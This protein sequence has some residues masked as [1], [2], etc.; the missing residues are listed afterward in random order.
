MQSIITKYYPCNTVL[1]YVRRLLK[2]VNLKIIVHTLQS[3]GKRVS[4]F[5][6]WYNNIMVSGVEVPALFLLHY[7]AVVYKGWNLCLYY[8]LQHLSNS[9]EIKDESW[10]HIVFFWLSVWIPLEW[11][12]LSLFFNSAESP[13]PQIQD[14]KS[15]SE[16]KWFKTLRQSEP[17]F[18]FHTMFLQNRT[19]QKLP[20]TPAWNRNRH[21]KRRAS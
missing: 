12:Y 20:F 11:S 2:M 10:I 18:Q 7:C 9:S 4:A 14:L 13:K 6:C 8:I 17:P 19:K 1:L 16:P 5:V 15:E 21:L 3:T